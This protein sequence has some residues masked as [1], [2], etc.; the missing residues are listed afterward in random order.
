MLLV[1]NYFSFSLTSPWWSFSPNS[2]PSMFFRFPGWCVVFFPTHKTPTAM[3]FLMWTQE[4]RGGPFTLEVR[5][6]TVYQTIGVV[7][8]MACFFDPR[9]MLL[10]ET[11]GWTINHVFF[12]EN[13]W[14]FCF[15]REV[16]LEIHPFFTEPCLWEEGY[17][18]FQRFIW[19]SMI[20]CCCQFSM[21]QLLE[22]WWG[23]YMLHNVMFAWQH[24]CMHTHTDGW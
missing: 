2:E 13:G 1:F 23:E 8:P 20:S 19:W 7:R 22:F 24:P 11:W 15:E 12:V 9:K 10:G 17:V 6:P 16:L 4:L 5:P 18:V 3:I 14:K 21:M